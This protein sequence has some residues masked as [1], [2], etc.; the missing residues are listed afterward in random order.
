M[1]GT[2]GEQ[3]LAG[4]AA[5]ATGS[6]SPDEDVRPENLLAR[7][8]ERVADSSMDWRRALVET[9]GQWPLARESVGER[10]FVY[11]IGGEAFDWRAL[12]DRL[13]EACCEEVPKAEREEMLTGSG[14]PANMGEDEWMRTLGV[15]KYRAHLNYVYGV[16]V[17]QALQVAVQ[18]EICKRNVGNGYMPGEAECERAYER[19]YGMGLI[20]LW[21]EF[22]EEVPVSLHSGSG[23]DGHA[24]ADG[25]VSGCVADGDEF[26]YWL[27][28]RR[29]AKADPARVASDTRKGL[30]QLE[31]IRRSHARR[32]GLARKAGRRRPSVAR[33]NT[34]ATR[35][36]EQVQSTKNHL[37]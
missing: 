27:F 33:K 37:Q 9:M 20:E 22:R 5:T 2:F 30:L 8:R 4:E 13:I 12:A 16:T 19:L 25:P 11:L 26:A 36:V 3:V 35:A 28:K 10:R 24:R 34:P 21:A 15:E 6:P 23:A 31:K 18:E 17:E 14:L 1:T 32:L 29:V 7:L